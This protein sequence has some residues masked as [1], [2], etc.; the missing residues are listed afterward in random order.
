MIVAPEHKMSELRVVPE[1]QLDRP[2]SPSGSHSGD[3]V[4]DKR[5]AVTGPDTT[6][7]KDRF[8]DRSDK[9]VASSPLVSAQ[10]SVDA[11]A[12]LRNHELLL[13]SRPSSIHDVS[14]RLLASPG[15]QRRRSAA[16]E[17][18]AKIG[19]DTS[20][21][22]HR[23]SHESR[24]SGIDFD[25]LEDAIMYR[26]SEDAGPSPITAENEKTGNALTDVHNSPSNRTESTRFS[27]F[28]SKLDSAIH[29]TNIEGLVP[30]NESLRDLF[31]TGDHEGVWWL[32]A[33]DPTDE[34]ID[35]LSKAFSIHPLTSEDIKTRETREKIELFK[36]YY[37]LSF[38]MPQRPDK[39]NNYILPAVNLYAV[40]F[41]EGVLSFTFCKNPHASN[42]LSRISG[43]RN[44]LALTS[45]WICYALIDDIV[46]GFAPLIQQ[47]EQEISII[48]DSFSLARADDIG[49][50]LQ[51]IYGCRRKIV[52]IRRLL[53]GK[54]DVI[55][56]FARHC[57]EHFSVTAYNKIALY[58][59]DIL[60]HV[61]TM[62]SNLVHFEKMLSR[63]HS[64]YLAQLSVDSGV[65]GTRT[66]EA[67][68]K[69]TFIATI[70]VPLNILCSLFG[71]N[72]P[73]PGKDTNGLDWW[74]GILGGIL[75]VI[76]VCLLV[77]K[78][79]KII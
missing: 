40:V 58:F 50:V 21:E 45:D 78:R 75:A 7:Q 20:Y 19:H 66:I 34:D 71:M 64:N 73:I 68:S 8:A 67:L 38:C 11:F 36:D 51:Q 4:E 23:P 5:D 14:P 53:D 31:D 25:F 28:S 55:K 9:S 24:S 69:L 12:A 52:A 17:D 30:P 32:D 33:T 27:F 26:H 57:N 6:E 37:F 76:V 61:T 18:G 3:E 49:P 70:L 39:T 77:A 1:I 59:G 54:I 22:N 46:D 56:S 43:L 2:S 41:R 65:A 74:F 60:D 48:E 29:A 16:T 62:V 35:V 72:I 79:M 44:Q 10:N 13:D 63:S 42:V 15:S 47:I